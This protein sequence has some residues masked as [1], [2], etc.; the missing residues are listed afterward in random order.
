MV[1]MWDRDDVK[2]EKNRKL[3]KVSDQE[4]V[5]RPT[6]KTHMLSKSAQEREKKHSTGSTQLTDKTERNDGR[7][8]KYD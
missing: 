1:E 7:K 4:S 6:F 2:F 3:R 8:N 5:E